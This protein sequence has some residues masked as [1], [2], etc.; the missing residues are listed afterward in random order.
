MSVSAGLFIAFLCGSD[1]SWSR[2]RPS[3]VS[4]VFVAPLDEDTS[5]GT[6]QE[7]STFDSA[8]G[9]CFVLR[10]EL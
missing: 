10:G 7:K 2:A 3:A 9:R 4:I 8:G 5:C 6:G 1:G